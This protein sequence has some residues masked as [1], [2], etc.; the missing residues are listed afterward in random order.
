VQDLLPGLL[1]RLTLS[2]ILLALLLILHSVVQHVN[3]AE[4]IN[5]YLVMNSFYIPETDVFTCIVDNSVDSSSI[6]SRNSC[7][8]LALSEA[9]KPEHTINI[10]SIL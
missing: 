1:D 7:S 6:C 5:V 8:L 10:I 3:W 2:D 9:D 4:Y